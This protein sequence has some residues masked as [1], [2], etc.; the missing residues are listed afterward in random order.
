MYKPPNH[1]LKRITLINSLRSNKVNFSQL[2]D[3]VFFSNIPFNQLEYLGLHK[4]KIS[5]KT[6]LDTFKLFMNTNP[7][8][9]SLK[10]EECELT[11]SGIKTELSPLFSQELENLKILD[12]DMSFKNFFV[13]DLANKIRFISK[14]IEQLRLRALFDSPNCIPNLLRQIDEGFKIFKLEIDYL[15]TEPFSKSAM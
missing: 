10:L 9:K 3:M 2:C 6:S 5:E 4:I 12:I 15:G 14:D 1:K 11:K 8:I 13:G 7:T